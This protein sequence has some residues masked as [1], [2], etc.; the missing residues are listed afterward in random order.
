MITNNS[1]IEQNIET[2]SSHTDDNF[3]AHDLPSIQNTSSEDKKFTLDSEDDFTWFSKRESPTT[4]LF[5]VTLTRTITQDIVYDCFP[6]VN[7]V[8]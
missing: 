6:F 1:V 7:I 4:V 3:V 8:F 2:V 5:K